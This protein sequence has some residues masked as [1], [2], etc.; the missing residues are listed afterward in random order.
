MKF[1]VFTT[2]LKYYISAGCRLLPC[3]P[4]CLLPACFGR[5][6][7]VVIPRS[8][9]CTLLIPLSPFRSLGQLFLSHQGWGSYFSKEL[10]QFQLLLGVELPNSSYF[11]YR[12]HCEDLT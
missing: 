9:I 10:G 11:S 12:H 2:R 7:E 6:V 5:D 1:A 4:A 3:F 8:W